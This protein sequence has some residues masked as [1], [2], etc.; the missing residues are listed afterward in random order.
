MRERG[1]VDISLTSLRAGFH[2]IDAA[3]MHPYELLGY[4]E[5]VQMKRI[6]AFV[7]SLNV[8]GPEFPDD[9]LVLFHSAF[10]DPDRPGLQEA[11]VC[12][13]MYRKYEA[14]ADI[15]KVGIDA[16]Y[17][18]HMDFSEVEGPVDEWYPKQK[19]RD[20]EYLWFAFTRTG[21]GRDG[22][23]SNYYLASGQSSQ[24]CTLGRT[25]NS[26]SKMDFDVD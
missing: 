17:G 1:K 6:D 8:K 25:L 16:Y 2:S 20:L 9:A 26:R 14:Y 24:A 4:Y 5:T 23:H 22:F 7:F 10:D 21:S 11:V 15:R 13:V 3:G 12:K 19:I 18:S